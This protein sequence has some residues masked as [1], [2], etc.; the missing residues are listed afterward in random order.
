VLGAVV[1]L[2]PTTHKK[3]RTDFAIH[4]ANAEL[5]GHNINYKTKRDLQKLPETTT[6]NLSLMGLGGETL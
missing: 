2:E 6:M 3:I 1:G 5:R 4:V